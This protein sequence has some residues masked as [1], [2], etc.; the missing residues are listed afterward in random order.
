MRYFNVIRYF[1]RF[2]HFIIWDQW[3]IDWMP[4]LFNLFYLNLPLYF[5]QNKQLSIIANN[6]IIK[7]ELPQKQLE[8]TIFN[9][10]FALLSYTTVIIWQLSWALLSRYGK[11]LFASVTRSLF[12]AL[13]LQLIVVRGLTSNNI[14]G[15]YICY[16]LFP[17]P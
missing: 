3:V 11:R 12:L 16:Y 10:T 5:K 6:K 7:D 4:L 8:R 14:S 17:S 9:Q 1:I 15:H 13:V 2:Q